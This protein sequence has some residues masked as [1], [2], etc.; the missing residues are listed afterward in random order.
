[1]D[2]ALSKQGT[3][4]KKKAAKKTK[5]KSPSKK[6]TAPK[7]VKKKAPTAKAA[8]P[9]AGV[10]PTAGITQSDVLGQVM[11]L[12]LRS[13]QHRHLFLAD[14]EWLILP[15]LALRQCRVIRQKEQPV[16]FIS[17]GWLSKETE[18]R[19]TNGGVG[20]NGLR[21]QAN[22]WNA[23]AAGGDSVNNGRTTGGDSVNSGRGNP[24]II[25]IIA[26]YGGAEK[27]IAEVKKNVFKGEKVKAFQQAP[28]GT[29][30]AV[31]EW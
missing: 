31:V 25:D 5:Q 30:M 24:W 15:P 4:A 23:R 14:L 28:D 12:M 9:L 18:K 7:S 10:Q 22:E 29:G 3:G 13:P 11:Q 16:A 19:L 21:L 6:P 20:A 26:P 17:W 8:S 2:Y 1:M 27:L